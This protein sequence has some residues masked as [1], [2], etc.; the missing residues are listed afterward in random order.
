MPVV[1]GK[2]DVAFPC[3]NNT[4]TTA[5]PTPLKSPVKI[6]KLS[7]SRVNTPIE[8][9][10]KFHKKNIPIIIDR[11]AAI[12]PIANDSLNKLIKMENLEKPIA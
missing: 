6:I 1:C 9:E 5:S 10:K 3:R 8:K 2:E 4:P 12:I 11:P 7:N